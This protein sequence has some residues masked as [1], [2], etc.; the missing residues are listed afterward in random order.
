MSAPYGHKTYQNAVLD[1]L[2]RYLRRCA[3]MNDPARAFAEVTGELWGRR[4]D[5]RP[6]TNLPDGVAL[7]ED[8]PFICLRV[9]TGGGKTVIGARSIRVARDE[10][11]DSDHPL[12]LWLVPSEAIRAQTLRQMR[13]RRTP[14]RQVLQEEL[15][16]V[17]VLDL[18]EAKYITRSVLD[19][20]PV[21]LVSTIQSFRVANTE[22]RKVYDDNGA[23][24]SHFDHV[25]DEAKAGLPHGFPHSLA[26]VLRL[27]RP[28]VIMDE[29]QN[30]RTR[31]SMVMLE[32]FQ[33]RAVIEFTATP[34]TEE[35]TQHSPSNVLH[36]VSASELKAERMIKLP[37]IVDCQTGW[38]ELLGSALALRE[39]L[40]AKAQEEQ[41]AGATYLRPLLLIQAEP[42][43]QQ[44]ETLNVDA[45]EKALKE[46][47]HVPA[48]QIA[49]ATGDRR[50]L[51]GEDVMTADSKIRFIITQQ[52][53]REGWDCSWAYVL[54][55]LADVHSRISAEQILG[56]I[57][58]QPGAQERTS[59]ELNR[60]YAFIRSPYF[61]LA[62]EPL[63][64]HL[65]TED[66]FDEREAASF[67]AP[68][69]PQQAELPIDAQGRRSVTVTLSENFRF[70]DLDLTA[71]EHAKWEPITKQL[72][73][74]GVPDTTDEKELLGAVTAAE[75]KQQIGHAV[76][77]LRREGRIMEAPADRGERFAVPRLLIYEQGRL[78]F[79]EESQFLSRA[80]R[81]PRPI[82][83][84]DVPPLAGLRQPHSVGILDVENG[85]VITRQMPELQCELEL[86]EAA[87]NWSRARLVAWIDRNLPHRDLPAEE[88]GVWL[89]SIIDALEQRGNTLGSLVRDRFVL[90][91]ALEQRIG[92][93][94]RA[95]ERKWFQDLLF[96]EASA[97]RVRVGNEH[98]FAFDPYAYP[99]RWT[100]PRSNEFQKHYYEKVGE[101][102]ERG[103]EFDCA[104][105]LDGLAP[106]AWWVRNLERQPNFSFWLQT[107]TDRFYP[108][109]VCELHDGRVLV[110]EYKNERD[111][112]NDD[113]REKRELGELWAERSRGRC[114]FFM[115]RGSDEMPRIA[116]L[117]A[118]RRRA[119]T[120][121]RWPGIESD[122]AIC[123]GEACIA[124][125]RIPVWVLEQA[126]R[127][128]ANEARVLRDYPGLK[129]DDVRAA[130]TYARENGAEIESDRV[131]NEAD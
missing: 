39:K 10:L 33:P 91:R 49:V 115:P 129:P 121:G 124:N 78:V 94:R 47:F 95:A 77:M 65:V 85:K 29:A 59:E 83:D 32:R 105:S 126:R 89:N 55:S 19:G 99:A 21:I 110:V 127:Q 125:T 106:V 45:V 62:A 100:C 104:R 66:G 12:V 107:S 117:T 31:E 96:G 122:P 119:A 64:E 68:L 25:P 102:E 17:E 71:R 90:R 72:T 97:E 116:E 56:R 1:S 120:T 54:C 34:R 6:A 88:T 75:N 16:Q 48:E 87:E 60:C 53:L 69:N 9:P 52:A 113:N 76:R 41:A 103:E 24:M 3:E 111:W 11:L 61:W 57:M 51:E 5:Y 118:P 58:R 79:P 80:W 108:D 81:L 43:S 70:D 13:D 131:D 8:M 114:L 84:A 67:V 63:R 128:G 18:D 28:L 82:T 42:R 86:L 50:E 44:R 35:T 109:F 7:P 112:S 27:R 98:S 101:L 46:D 73:V 36:S 40:E 30:A 37:I 4:S 2:R 92:V 14:L 23:L 20:S 38:K 15:G 74:S 130:W 93:L 123:G 26:N 22:G